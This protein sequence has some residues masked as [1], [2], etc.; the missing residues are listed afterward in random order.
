MRRARRRGPDD[1]CSEPL[2]SERGTWD[3]THPSGPPALPQAAG[4]RLLAVAS[5]RT[6]APR[7]WVCVRRAGAVRSESHTEQPDPPLLFSPFFSSPSLSSSFP[8]PSPFG[9]AGLCS[10]RGT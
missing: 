6:A 5:P 4:A 2:S 3:A 8:A 9:A 7:P 10:P 1:I